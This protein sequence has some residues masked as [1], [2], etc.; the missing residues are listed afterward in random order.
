MTE[1]DRIQTFSKAVDVVN[2]ELHSKGY[3]FENLQFLTTDWK[4]F[5]EP[6]SGPE[7][8]AFVESNAVY[9]NEKHVVNALY[10]LVE[11]MK[12][13]Q[14]QHQKF[15]DTISMKQAEIDQL[16]VRCDSLESRNKTLEA[17]LGQEV[18]VNRISAK[19]KVALKEKLTRAQH[20]EIIKLRSMNSVL[21]SRL[22]IASKK[23]EQETSALRDQLLDQRNLSSTS[24]FGRP[25]M[26]QPPRPGSQGEVPVN[27]NILY[28]NKASINNV[29]EI[30]LSAPTEALGVALAQE[31]EGVANQLLELIDNLLK[32]NAKYA[33][34]I[35][36]VNK[37]IVR[38]NSEILDL[39]QRNF[40]DTSLQ[41]PSR[42]IDMAQ[43]AQ[44][45]TEKIET[46][47]FV[48]K[49]FLSNIYTNF[50]YVEGLI[51]LLAS[52]YNQGEG[53]QQESA[54][55]RELRKE[56]DHLRESLH[57]ALK[58]LEEWKKLR[59]RK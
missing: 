30:S 37:Y 55:L 9:T 17:K 41:N 7:I 21:Q 59:S 48:S 54:A 1:P 33:R 14:Q 16:R 6:N 11:N 35:G 49:P 18:G 34:F 22:Q 40:S 36:S 52:V 31:H 32:E 3:I 44:E 4:K 43:I 25:M 10:T 26:L 38:L 27:T 19:N 39:N 58:A 28:N 56:N 45:T 50:H 51:E 12:R 15:S 53:F 42:A 8:Q 5:A 13:Q 20:G 23:H 2:A 47:E 24:T 29:T 46:F 57:D